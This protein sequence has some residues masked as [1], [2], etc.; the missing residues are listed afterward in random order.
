MDDFC[1]LYDVNSIT[2]SGNQQTRS[3]AKK[4]KGE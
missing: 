1:N 4:D 3:C 2:Y